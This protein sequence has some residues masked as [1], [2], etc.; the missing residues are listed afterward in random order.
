MNKQEC[1]HLIKEMDN[2]GAIGIFKCVRCG[3]T[4]IG[5]AKDVAEYRRVSR[6][7]TMSPILVVFV[8]L[9]SVLL[10]LLVLGF[11]L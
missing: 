7:R 11:L 10:V 8:V 2:A 5:G 4:I 3:E 6:F 9:V 1:N